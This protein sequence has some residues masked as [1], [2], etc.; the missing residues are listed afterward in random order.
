MSSFEFHIMSCVAAGEVWD[1]VPG[2]LLPIMDQEERVLQYL[3]ISP[4]L[5]PIFWVFESKYTRIKIYTHLRD[6]SL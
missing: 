1:R 5:L 2:R 3:S 4:W 6:K